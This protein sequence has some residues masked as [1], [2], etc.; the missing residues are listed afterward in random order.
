MQKSTMSRV[1]LRSVCNLLL[2]EDSLTEEPRPPVLIADTSISDNT[3]APLNTEEP[4]EEIQNH[5]NSVSDMDEE[6]LSV[7]IN[8]QNAEPDTKHEIGNHIVKSQ[9]LSTKAT[10]TDEGCL[11]G[12]FCSKKV[13][14]L[15][16]R[17]LSEVEIQVLDKRLDFAPIQRS[18]NEPEQRKDFEDFSRRMLIS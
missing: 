13:F 16:Q 3:S 2:S 14:N 8:L 10:V 18:I 6:L 17:V 15:S 11:Q 4:W 9:G 7:L 5:D 1:E 12:S